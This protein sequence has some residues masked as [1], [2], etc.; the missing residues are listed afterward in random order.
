MQASPEQIAVKNWLCKPAPHVSPCGCTGRRPGE[1]VCPCALRWMEKVGD[2][3]YCIHTI[4]VPE[5]GVERV[6][7]TEYIY[8]ARQ[9]QL[10]K[11]V[12]VLMLR[13]VLCLKSPSSNG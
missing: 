3:W 11:C 8:P 9:L 13:E 7:A 12:I 2:K 6:S 5:E 4:R 10:S 1:P